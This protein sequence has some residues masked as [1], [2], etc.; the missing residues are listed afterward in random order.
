MVIAVN[1]IIL[2]VVTYRLYAI[3]KSSLKKLTIKNGIR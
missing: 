2:N 3:D 1:Q